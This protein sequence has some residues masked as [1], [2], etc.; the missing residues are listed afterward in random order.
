M[1]TG[2]GFVL[3]AAAGDVWAI[4]NT[5]P[6]ASRRGSSDAT[7]RTRISHLAVLDRRGS[8]R[9]GETLSRHDPFPSQR[10]PQRR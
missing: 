10:R 1:Q 4:T 7:E 2:A 5:R 3:C 6:A 9:A 8:L